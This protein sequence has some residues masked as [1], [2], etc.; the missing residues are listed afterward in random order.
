MA[1]VRLDDSTP[2]E[3]RHRVLSDSANWLLVCLVA[4]SNRERTDG[5]VERP[6]LG[7]VRPGADPAQQAA[8]L[9]ELEQAGA[10]TATATGWQIVWLLDL[11]PCASEIE[12]RREQTRDRQR[13]HRER[14]SQRDATRDESVTSRVTQRV[15]HPPPSR[16]VPSRPDPDPDP[17]QKERARSKHVAEATPDDEI[18]EDARPLVGDQGRW[19]VWTRAYQLGYRAKYVDPCPVTPKYAESMR[20]LVRWSIEAQLTDDECR[21]ICTRFFA[22]NDPVVAG[23]K[24]WIGY[25]PPRLTTYRGTSKSTPRQ[26]GEAYEL[27]KP[28]L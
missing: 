11:Q 18:P 19:E 15:S 7:M 4:Y 1:W 8:A 23:G 28:I 17:D 3:R 26:S 25:L 10:L 6:E 16:P 20:A 5:A 14:M 22:D 21:L 12:R 9:A 2:L 13:K 27:A 24:W